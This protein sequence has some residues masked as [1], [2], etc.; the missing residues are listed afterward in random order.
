MPSGQ[1]RLATSNRQELQQ[2]WRRVAKAL[3]KRASVLEVGA[4]SCIVSKWMMG[5]RPD[6]HIIATDCGDYPIA[7]VDLNGIEFLPQTRL[8]VLPFAPAAFDAVVSQ[9]A[10]EYAIRSVALSECGRVLRPGGELS[11][12]MHSR[13]GRLHEGCALRVAVGR[14]LLAAPSIP[15]LLQKAARIKD[16]RLRSTMYALSI[17]PHLDQRLFELGQMEVAAGV[18]CA[19]LRSY[20]ETAGRMITH[21]GFPHW[22][23]EAN[24]NLEMDI[25]VGE[26]Q[27]RVSLSDEDIGSLAQLARAAQLQPSKPTLK[28]FYWIWSATKIV[29]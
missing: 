8:E 6:L 17:K 12:I 7:E 18:Q 11:F 23:D 9:F 26:D 25:F 4:G 20:M 29:G 27:L 16:P 1:G 28:S 21:P 19:G 10:F 24:N 2:H 15:D 5:A 3:P 22:I 14:M 13:G